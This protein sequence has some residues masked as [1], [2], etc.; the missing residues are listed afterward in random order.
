MRVF[1]AGAGGAV[2]RR[3]VPKL[4]ERGH[5][6]VA[7]TRSAGKLDTLRQL[8]ACPVVMDGLDAA[9][10]GE[11][12]ARA[13]PDVV[14][15]QMTAL[16]DF[17]DLRRFDQGFAGTN[18][19]R[20]SGTDHLLAAADAVGVPRVVAQ[21]FTGW[22]NERTG[23]RV[24]TE[25]DPL[26]PHPPAEQRSSLAAIRYLEKAVTSASSIEGIVLR[27]GTLYGPGT[28][29]EHEYPALIRARKFPLI[30]AGSGIW[31][32]LHIDDAAAATAIAVER[33]A[34]GIYN[35]VDNEPAEVASWLPYLAVCLGAEPP[36]RIPRWL[37]RYAV[38]EVGISM[39]TMI[40]GSSN[41]KARRDLG[42]EPNWESWREGFL[43]LP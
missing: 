43:H 31:S 9:S 40:R 1:V 2:G 10:V 12:V 35:V 20:R 33:G 42:W 34:P 5:Q 28:A 24:K 29:M 18:E 27:Y 41:A 36:R 15:H 13:E 4:V 3:L 8:G 26:D 11:T 32:F 14:V 23:S 16:A 7:A 37:A 17:T 22:P 38:G 30:G 19:L 6:V 39:M 25:L 21:S